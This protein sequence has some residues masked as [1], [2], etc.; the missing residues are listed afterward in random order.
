MTARPRSALTK[1]ARKSI[2]CLIVPNTRMSMRLNP[3]PA[4]APE[5]P[6]INSSRAAIL[7]GE[8]RNRTA[9]VGEACPGAPRLVDP[10]LPH[11]RETAGAAMNDSLAQ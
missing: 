2:S 7:A 9:I 11:S 6:K 5:T 8:R 3:P 1:V 10:G 4:P